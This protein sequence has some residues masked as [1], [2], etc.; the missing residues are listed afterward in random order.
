MPGRGNRQY[1]Y[2]GQPRRKECRVAGGLAA[3]ERSVV[4]SE[5]IMVCAVERDARR[6]LRYSILW[7]AERWSLKTTAEGLDNEM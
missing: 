5:K 7:R 6:A 2:T 1:C 4:K 3:H